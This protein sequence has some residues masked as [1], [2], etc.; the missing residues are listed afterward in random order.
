MALDINKIIQHKLNV[1]Q[2][3]EEEHP[4]S[5][6]YLHHT[7]GNSNPFICVDGWNQNTER[8]GTA[9]V[10]AGKPKIGE[11]K[12]KDGD[13]IQCFSS[14]HW[15]YHLGVPKETFTKYGIKYQPLDKTS[16]GVELCNWGQVTKQPNGTFKNYVGGVV[17]NE[18]VVDLGKEFRGF[19]YYHAYSDAQL[20]SLRD[21]IIY[22]CDKYKISKKYN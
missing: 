19:R 5:Q 11:T 4:K 22:L 16:I 20:N 1:G 8:I 10:I 6:F 12:Y 17:P 18:D 2:F 21:L 7:A 13:I 3:F 14:K 15:C 9:F